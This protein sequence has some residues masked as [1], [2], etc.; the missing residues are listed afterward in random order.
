MTAL[1]KKSKL[2]FALVFIALYVLL[3]SV[4]D[5]LSDAA[6]IS[7]I[8]TVPTQLFLFVLILSFIVRQK[9]AK[10]FGLCKAESNKSVFLFY[11]P[12]FI[13]MSVN[14]WNGVTL[15][16]PFPDFLLYI[17]SMLLVGFLEEIIFRALLFNALLENGVKSAF[18]ISSLTF[19]IGH[20][21]NLLNGAEL[22]PTVL[23]IVSAF[24]IGFLFTLI[25]YKSKSLVICI[26]THGVFNSL[27]VFSVEGSSVRRII[28]CIA[29]CTLC[30]LYLLWIIKKSPEN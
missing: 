14:L 26:I 13:M 12:L 24:A 16:L 18:I 7:K 4:A 8:I 9:L 23:Q 22:L 10:T 15:N 5:S 25:Y 19:G 6:G 11:I 27:S 20:I 3:S 17:I 28:T 1:Y 2:A 29:I 30:A 21:V